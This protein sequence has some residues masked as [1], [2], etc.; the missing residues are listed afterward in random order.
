MSLFGDRPDRPRRRFAFLTLPIMVD[1]IVPIFAKF[2]GWRSDSANA[3]EARGW[4]FPRT[5]IGDAGR[6]GD[7]RAFLGGPS[8]V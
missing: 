2:L 6:L 7:N 8:G 5:R 3:T 1:W 4:P